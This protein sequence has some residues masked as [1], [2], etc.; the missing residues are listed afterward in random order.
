MRYPP[1]DKELFV[2]NRKRLSKELKSNSI[3]IFTANDIMPTN[4]DGT[5]AFKQNSELYYLSGIDQEES[6]LVIYPDFHDKKLREILFLRE[7]YDE[8]AIWEGHKYTKKEAREASGID[9]IFWLSEFN[10][11]FNTLMVEAE[12]VYIL[13]RHSSTVLGLN[14]PVPKIVA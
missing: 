11:V 14:N 10:K 7:T 13:L 6:I 3:S 4:A 1:I 5:M 8:I 9:T 12:Y 2:S